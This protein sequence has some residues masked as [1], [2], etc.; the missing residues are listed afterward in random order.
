[1]SFGC[2]LICFQNNDITR[3][4]VYIIAINCFFFLIFIFQCRRK[5]LLVSFTFIAFF[6]QLYIPRARFYLLFLF[7]SFAGSSATQAHGQHPLS[8]RTRRHTYASSRGN[9]H[10]RTST[11]AICGCSLHVRVIYCIAGAREVMIK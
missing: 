7:F 8:T 6:L 10:P 4:G 5:P 3:T 11:F 9:S 2:A 1:M